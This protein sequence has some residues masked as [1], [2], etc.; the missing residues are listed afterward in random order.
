MAFDDNQTDPTLP[1]GNKSYRRESVNH[2][3]KYY[4]SEFN[5]KFLHATLDQMIQPGS[6]EKISGFYGRKTAKAFNH[7]T[8]IYVGDI[9]DDRENYQLEPALVIKDDLGNVNF[10]ADYIDFVNAVKIQN[11]P[12]SK[13]NLL[14]SAESYAW[15]PHIDWDKF[16]NFRNYYWLPNGPETITV[17]GQSKEIKSQIKIELSNNVDNFTYI[18]TPDGLTNNPTLTLFRGQTYRFLVNA[19][20]YPIAFV[21][22]ITFTPGR[23]YTDPTDNT[24]LIYKN[25]ITNFDEDGNVIRDNFIE[26]G[27]IEFTVPQTAPDNLYY[28]SKEDPNL[29]GMIKI[30]DLIENTEINVEKEILGKAFYTTSQGWDLSNGMKLNFVGDVTPAKYSNGEWYV[31]GVGDEII[32]INSED[33]ELNSLFVSNLDVQFDNKGF[34]QLPYDEAIGYAKNKDYIVINRSS[35]DGNLWSKYNRWFHIDVIEKSLELNQQ[36]KNVDQLS[37]AFR[38]IIEFEAN[39]KLFQF[40]TKSKKNVNLVDTVTKDVFST[41]EGSLGYNIDGVNLTEGMRILFLADT[42]VLV[43]NRIFE[44]K[45]IVVNSNTQITLIET[46]DSIPLINESVL[47]ISGT[48]YKG[49]YFYYDGNDWVLSQA[50]TSINQAPL[51]DLFDKN[52]VWLKDP[53]IYEYSQF[54][55]NKLFSYQTGDGAVDNELGFPLLYQNIT[56]SGDILFYFDLINDSFTYFK[57]NSVVEYKTD[58]SFLRKYTSK[59]NY[60]VINGWTKSSKDN[61]PVIKQY[62]ATTS[63][64]YPLDM[65]EDVDFTSIW[66]KVYVNNKI[67]NLATDYVIERDINNFYFIRFF[68]LNVNDNIIIKSKAKSSKTDSGYFSIPNNLEKNPLNDNL[69]SFTLGEVIDHVASIVENDSRFVGEF[70]GKGNLRDLQNLSQYG[71][72][73]YKHSS[74]F[75][76]YAYHLLDKSSNIIDAIDYVKIE[77]GKFKRQFLEIATNLGFTG[78]IKTHVDKILQKFIEDKKENFPFY[79]S[80]MV[81]IGGKIVNS[82]IVID[83]DQMYWNLSKPFQLNELSYN[84]VGVYKNQKQLLYGLDYDFSEDGFVKI[85]GNKN[86]DD[87][88]E[89]IEYDSTV[90]CFVPPSPTK[91]GL[92]PKFQPDLKINEVINKDE[93]VDG[94]GPFKAYGKEIIDGKDDLIGWFYPVYVDFQSAK[95]ADIDNGGLGDVNI[96]ILNGSTTSFYI[97]KT[98][99]NSGAEDS[100]AYEELNLGVL[101]LIGHD[102]S[103]TVAYKDYRDALILELEYRIFNNIKIEYDPSL[104]DIHEVMPG[105]GRDTGF[106]LYEFNKAL[107]TDFIT[108]TKFVNVEYTDNVYYNR[109]NPLTYNYNKASFSNGEK[110]P[111]YWPGIYQYLYDTDLPHTNPWEMLGFKIKPSWWDNQYGSPPYTSNNLLLWEDLSKGIIRK[112]TY[113]VNKKYIRPYLLENIPVDEKGVLKSPNLLNIIKNKNS[114][115]YTDEFLFGDSSPVEMAWKRSSDYPFSIIKAC[116]LLRPAYMF[117]TGFDRYNQIRDLSGQLVY[118]STKNHIQLKNINFPDNSTSTVNQITSGL[119]NF[120]VEY[121]NT[122]FLNKFDQYK[123]NVA[124]I[125]NQISFKVGGFTDKNKFNLILDSR[126]PLNEGNIF[127]PTENYTIFKN[128][129]FPIDEISYSGVIIER[130]IKGFI[131]KGYDN[132]TAEFKYIRVRKRDADVYFNVGGITETFLDWQTGKNYEIGS[133]VRVGTNSFYRTKV[134]HVAGELFDST[135]FV[136]IPSLPVTGGVDAKYRQ[137]FESD[138]E[139]LNYGTVLK[140]IQ[141]VV[142][143]LFGYGKYLESVG[144]VFDTF[145]ADTSNLADWFHSIKQFMFWTT[146]TWTDDAVI[147][148]SP[149]AYALKFSSE[150]A[151]VGN[152]QDTSLGYSILQASGD[153]IK[154]NNLKFYRDKFNK[155]EIKPV[156]TFAGIYFVRLPLVLKEHVVIIDNKTVFND[157]IYDLQPGYRQERILVFGYRTAN[158]T[159]GFDIPGFFY[160]DANI[161]NFVPW[162]DYQT[163]DIVKFKEYYYLANDRILGTADFDFSK[164]KRLPSKPVQQLFSNFD[165]KV[166]QFKDFYDLDSDNLDIEQQK[167]AQH[168]I[169]YQKRDYLKNIIPN[170]ISQYKFYQGFI[171]DKGTK[172]SLIKLFDV[173]SNTDKDSLEFFEEWAIRV[174]LY[175]GVD[176]FSEYSYILPEKDFRLNP[177]PVLI[178]DNTVVDEIDLILR[179]SKSNAY[180]KPDTNNNYNLLPTFHIGA[181]DF[182]FR[183]AGYVD[184]DNVNHTLVIIDELL[185]KNIDDLL[186]DDYLWVGNYKKSW[187]VFQYKKSNV[188]IK[189]VKITGSLITLDLEK[190]VDFIAVGDIIGIYEINLPNFNTGDSSVISLNITSPLRGFFEVVNV[191]QSKIDINAPQA[192]FAINYDDYENCNGVLTYFQSMRA[193]D[194][195][196]LETISI[197]NLSDNTKFWLD[198]NG[199]NEWN[200]IQ[201]NNK[202]QFNLSIDNL[203][204][205]DLSN[206]GTSIAVDDRNLHLAVGAP[207]TNDG[208]VYVYSRPTRNSQWQLIS[209]LEPNTS[210][211]VQKKFGQSIAMSGDSRYIIVGAP[212]DSYIPTRFLGNYVENIAYTQGDIVL[213]ND[214]LWEALIDIFPSVDAQLFSSFFNP[215]DYIA[216]AGLNVENVEY[217]NLLLSGNYPLRY[218]ESEDPVTADHF[219]Y[220]IEKVKFTGIK[221]GDKIKLHYNKLSN[222]N[223]NNLILQSTE[224]FG[225]NFTFVGDPNIKFSD[226]ITDT[227]IIAAKVELIINIDNALISPT[228]GQVIT[229]N[230]G[231]A[232]IVYVFSPFIGSNDFTLYL[233][234][235]RGVF[236]IS[237]TAYLLGNLVGN[238]QLVAPVDSY[239]F[240]GYVMLMVPPYYVKNVNADNGFNIVLVDIITDNT[241]SSVK[242]IN[243][244]D[245]SQTDTYGENTVASLIRSFSY[246]G[247]N[248]I[249]ATTFEDVERKMNYVGVRFPKE[250]TDTIN[251]GDNFNFYYNQLKKTVSLLRVR[252]TRYIVNPTVQVGEILTQKNTGVTATVISAEVVIDENIITPSNPVYIIQVQAVTA[253]DTNETFNFV[254]ELVGSVTGE[255]FIRPYTEIETDIYKSLK[256]IGAG[257]SDVLNGENEIWNLWDGYI[258]YNENRYSEEGLPFQPYPKYYEDGSGLLV[259]DPGRQGQIIR[260][261][262][263]SNT[264]EVMY[265]QRFSPSKVVVYVNNVQ[266]TWTQGALFGA[267]AEDTILEM[268]AIGDIQDPWDRSNIYTVNRQV[269]IIQKTSLGYEDTLGKLLI[270]QSSPFDITFNSL[271]IFENELKGEEYWYYTS[272]TVQGIEREPTIPVD[273]DLSWNEIYDIPVSTQGVT[274]TNINE[275]S[276]FIYEKLGN[277]YKLVKNIISNFRKNNHYFGAKVKI[278]EID[279]VVHVYVLSLDGDYDFNFP[280]MLHFIKY[281]TYGNITYNWEFGKNKNYKG[282]FSDQSIYFKDDIVLLNNTLYQAKTNLLQSYFDEIYWSALDN[283]TD[284]FGYIPNKTGVQISIDSVDISTIP[285]ENIY[286]YASNFEISNDGQVLAI[287]VKYETEKS[288]VIA[289]YR[290]INGAYRWYENI[291]SPVVDIEF[292]S[293]ISLNNDGSILIVGAPAADINFRDQGLVYIYRLTNFKF[294][295]SQT[296]KCPKEKTLDYFGYRVDI[297]NDILIIISLL[298]TLEKETIF[299]SSL[300]IFDSN[301]TKFTYVKENVGSVFVYEQLNNSFIYCNEFSYDEVNSTIYGIGKNIHLNK[302]HIYIGLPNI[303]IETNNI[304]SYGKV[305]EFA[306]D[307]SSLLSVIQS[308][309]YSVDLSKIKRVYLYNKKTRKLIKNLDY[310]DPL[311][312]KISGLAEQN[313]SFKTIY[314]PA[315][316]SVGDAADVSILPDMSWTTENVGKLWWDI[317]DVIFYNPMLASVTFSTNYWNKLFT[318]SSIDIYEWVESDIL[319]SVW[320]TLVSTGEGSTAGIVGQTKYGDAAYSVKRIYDPISKTFTEKYFYW[321]KNLTTIPELDNRNLSALNVSKLIENPFLA[322]YEFISLISDNEF[323]LFNIEKYTNDNNTA[324]GF[325]IYKYDNLSDMNKVHYQYNIFTDGLGTNIPNESL[326]TKWIDSLVGYDLFGRSVPDFSL[327]EKYKYGCLNDPRQSWFK[328]RQEALKQYIERINYVLKNQLIVDSKNLINLYKQ[329]N[330]PNQQSNIYD[331]EVDLKS[332]LDLY[333]IAKAEQAEIKLEIQNGEIVGVSIVNPGRGYLRKPTYTVIGKG[334]DLELDFTLTSIGSIDDVQIIN[335][336]E[337]YN[338]STYIIIRKFTALVKTD[339]TIL[340]KWA[341]Y[342]RDYA[343]K[344]WKR[345]QTQSFNLSLYWNFISWYAEGYSEN[346]KID[347]LIDY[348]YELTSIKD[349]IGSIVKIN[350]VGLGGWLLLLKI[351]DIENVDYTINY[352]T[353]GRQNGTIQF[354]SVLYD[355]N[356]AFKNFDL[357]SYDTDFYDSIPSKEIREI[358][359]IVKNDLFVDELAV[360]YNQLFIAAIKYVL[361]EQPDVD[362]IFKTNFLKVKHNLGSLRQDITFNNDNLPSYESYVNEVKPFK[363]KIRE[364]V[365]A[366]DRLENTS[367]LTTDFDLPPR[368]NSYFSK[369]LPLRPIVVNDVI[370]NIDSIDTYPDLNWVSNNTYSVTKVEII[371]GGLGYGVAPKLILEGGGG[372][373]AE[374]ICTIGENGKIASVTVTNS[375]QGYVSAPKCIINGSLKENGYDGK[376]SVIIGN[377]KV[378]SMKTVLKFDRINKNLDRV[379]LDTTESFVGSGSKYIFDLQWPISYNKKDVTISVDSKVL[380]KSD[381]TIEN[382]VDNSKGYSRMLGRIVFDTPIENFALCIIS[383]K[384]E[385]SFLH[386]QDRINLFYQPEINQYGKD[387]SLLLD[388]VDYGGVEV[389]SFGFGNTSGWD[390]TDYFSNAYDTYDMAYEDIVY[391]MPRNVYNFASI[392]NQ[393]EINF[394][395]F[396]KNVNAIVKGDSVNISPTFYEIFNVNAL[397][398]VLEDPLNSSSIL[399]VAD[400]NS[401]TVLSANKIQQYGINLE[402]DS[403]SLNNII[404]QIIPKILNLGQEDLTNLV[405]EGIL[406]PLIINFNTPLENGITYNVYINNVRV[407]D[408]N[409]ENDPTNINNPAAIMPSLVGDGIK[410]NLILNDYNIVLQDNDVVIIRKITSD[411][412]FLPTDLDYDSLL[413][414]GGLNYSNARGINAEEIVVDGDLFV[415]PTNAKSLEENVPGLVQDSVSISVFEKPVPGVSKITSRNYVGNG[416]DNTFSLGIT[417]FDND[418][419]FVKINDKIKIQDIDYKVDFSQ[420][421]IIF[422]DPPAL[423]DKIN[424]QTFNISGTNI[425]DMGVHI[426]DGQSNTFIVNARWEE[427]LTSQI[428]VDGEQV[429]YVLIPADNEEYDSSNNILI[430]FSESIPQGKTINYV[431]YAGAEQNY[432]EIY[433]DNF[434]A[435]GSTNIFNLTQTPF[436]QEPIE[437]FTL[438]FVNDV[439]L[440][441]GYVETFVLSTALEYRLKLWQVPLSSTSY[442]QIRVFLNNNELT[443]LTEW[444]FSAAESLNPLIDDSEQVGSTIKIKEGLGKQGDVLKVYIIGWKDSTVAGGDYRYGYY[445]DDEFVKTPGVI[446]IDVPMAQ[447]DNVKIYQFSNHDSQKIDWQSYDVTERTKLSPGIKINSAYRRVPASK[448]LEFDFI[449]NV[450]FLYTVYRNGIRIDDGNFGVGQQSNPNAEIPTIQGNG[451]RFLSLFDY[452]ISANEGDVIKIEEINDSYEINDQSK[453]WYELRQIRNGLIPLNTPAIDDNYVWVARNGFLLTPSVDYYVTHDRMFVKLYRELDELDNI[454]T[455]HFSNDAMQNK[456]AWRQFSDIL[457]KTHYTVLEGSKNIRLTKDLHWYDKEIEINDGN[458]LPNISQKSKFPNVIFVDGER[459]EYWQKN[460]NILYQLRRGTLGTGVKNIYKAGIEVYD[461]SVDKMLPY[462]DEIVSSTFI[463]DGSTN[464]FLLDF[465][466]NSI[467]EFEV[468]VAGIR[469][470]KTE[471]VKYSIELGQDSPESDIVLPPE[472]S[473][474]NN[475]LILDRAPAENNKVVILRR[476]GKLWTEPG[477]PLY[478]SNSNIAKILLSTEADLPR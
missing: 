389:R 355:P 25:G 180:V 293:S 348:S 109:L 135:K 99:E 265:L 292:G 377:S 414:G 368:F 387:L 143:F 58:I 341:L 159:G 252:N 167:I 21:S 118:R 402:V 157:I 406:K 66:L 357:I 388:G 384:K 362:W 424:L 375:G 224:P 93:L 22:K 275:G 443:Y 28:I 64:T 148:L 346:T 306:K 75:N 441:P 106:S 390:T 315:V 155:F 465:M 403:I 378:R 29:S 227:H 117:S 452:S 199:K 295:L 122:I 376:L 223:Q 178:T 305:I 436:M 419:I 244:L 281:G 257:L 363:A 344:F 242:Y 162:T 189:S 33:L 105:Y 473:I 185:E 312:G 120:V 103:R 256:D 435:D 411:G 163:G 246:R 228:V 459:I 6:V 249:N 320:D 364:F 221:P 282:L 400:E 166:A 144:F 55:G 188:K 470:R 98:L 126:T 474:N 260:Q 43:K 410:Q 9:S 193:K 110:V 26:N 133:I 94:T 42:D 53:I 183:T 385:I 195:D 215:S 115:T 219:L 409:F 83:S 85:F 301:F 68:K 309:K 464:E 467:N 288:N 300:T 404:T 422:T 15:D 310:I 263:T 147:T 226:V 442:N 137:Y 401:L 96:H 206:F 350:N 69:N 47:I 90:G 70:P 35:N 82:D 1:A 280:G 97:P 329:D 45:F 386:A 451:T 342:E 139:V 365:A 434:I 237:D 234:N 445:A 304:I 337:N 104:L 161:Q 184:P 201:R 318:N 269:G 52:D 5:K 330:Y 391:N 170:D 125:T 429:N 335:P 395:E 149:A 296:L 394:K 173:L 27:F 416:A 382:V 202:F 212:N 207:D 428:T 112:P 283:Y 469:L 154:S 203:D 277:E 313:I 213:Y 323:G 72:K 272:R 456:F 345:I 354:S 287:L 211:S 186:F 88:I 175:G 20:N 37:R 351:N 266:G 319:P 454:Q 356:E 108:Y 192:F 267:L 352:E 286:D 171:Q 176:I 421:S 46:N 217:P 209:L 432:S 360:E 270:I 200:V 250:L 134:T 79:L 179:L 78:P 156:N 107:L 50:K 408:P 425:L 121:Q 62:V 262:G 229:T 142:D 439:L 10:Y 63:K 145:I 138:I 243:V 60:E 324:I 19:P 194:I 398:E 333:G 71:S 140:T 328:N 407:D 336:G 218:F 34:D 158:W 204:D 30:Y 76:L 446:H 177:Q 405:S 463:G 146:Q 54:S 431:I 261:K 40:G 84:A 57:S 291:I 340:G 361:S 297:S 453:D 38:P 290:Y 366:Y 165:Y 230:N 379:S 129:C 359:K 461:Q 371:D 475:T 477:T 251:A 253:S 327:S 381:Y 7:K 77:Y 247:T 41:I 182:K 233:A 462:K 216:D 278:A 369:I 130:S 18:F 311:Q 374:A 268:L 417:P 307:T 478:K 214:R 81:P 303:A 254:D 468:F 101:L 56:N 325:E 86:V 457:N 44:V 276:V 430:K 298:G 239:D 208:K 353:I 114:S 415:T 136:K 383:Y 331:L 61:Q 245:Y 440:N 31:E 466:P 316:Y 259:S 423:N 274:S 91:L 197:K 264:A 450:D 220:R 113:T 152:T 347:Y 13:Q 210:N 95:Q 334:K 476:L 132:K 174:G 116:I 255:L 444:T 100:L 39:I 222:V 67:Q 367:S 413:S 124:L 358:A 123:K 437:W 447:G 321:V 426:A 51:F 460:G 164:W 285:L 258:E 471:L 279:N 372:T 111:G 16:V 65:Y 299:D 23:E 168:L 102:G 74:P 314:D 235:V 181:E 393:L 24:S 317:S 392:S 190:F 59:D 458:L 36:E 17:Y 370:T 187:T 2:L 49:K 127:I 418:L 322:G 373:G 338:D 48:E 332:D 14:N 241:E 232:E 399:N 438:V 87:T 433:I 238:Y 231:I 198:N 396:A 3:P 131:I 153:P 339:E 89:I 12:T 397:D 80:D 205:K 196:E 236:E 412:S 302:T 92:Y 349:E 172:N 119:I 273:N 449:L 294:E 326:E 448:I 380:L 240:G 225:D 343:A 420:K 11:A 284:V 32:L 427:D 128:T 73:F 308:Q 289:I 151:I 455:I 472:F 160:D 271:G 4:R 8:D 150:F 191:Y 169:G 141:D 248:I